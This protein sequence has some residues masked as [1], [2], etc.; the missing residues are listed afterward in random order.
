[1]LLVKCCLLNNNDEESM[2]ENYYFG[3]S[4]VIYVI[5]LDFISSDNI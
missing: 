4:F 1:M 3:L 2:F 5:S